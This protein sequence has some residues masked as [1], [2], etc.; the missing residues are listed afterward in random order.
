MRA[1]FVLL[2]VNYLLYM[3]QIVYLDCKGIYDFEFRIVQDIHF[4]VI[5]VKS[6]FLNKMINVFRDLV[7]K[8][9]PHI[10]LLPS[11]CKRSQRCAHVKPALLVTRL[12]IYYLSRNTSFD[13]SFSK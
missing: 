5:Y 9:S 1:L 2:R 7:K 11:S 6:W 10:N 8:R 3:W 12:S 4:V 13:S